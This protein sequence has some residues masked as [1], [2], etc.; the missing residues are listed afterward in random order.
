MSL[1]KSSMVQEE[2][3]SAFFDMYLMLILLRL[4]AH[5]YFSHLNETFQVNLERRYH[6][7]TI[8]SILDISN[9]PPSWRP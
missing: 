9:S 3:I 1:S 7:V 8:L 2:Y 5:L 4:Y 6:R